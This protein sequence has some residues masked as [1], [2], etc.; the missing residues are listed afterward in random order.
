MMGIAI[1]LPT[2]IYC[3]NQSVPWN[4]K[5]P[6][7]SL[8]K[9]SAAMAYHF[10][11]EGVARMEWVTNFVKSGSNPSD[12]MT[13]TVVQERKQKICMMLYDI[14]PEKDDPQE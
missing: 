4:T 8:K 11:R 9:K 2:L 6:D 5:V 12:D 7:S 13:K 3:D 1:N 10:F 14:Y